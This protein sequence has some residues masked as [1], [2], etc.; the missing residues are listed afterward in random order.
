MVYLFD[1]KGC[2]KNEINKKSV[3]GILKVSI[4]YYLVDF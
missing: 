2:K 1:F 4:K 3:V